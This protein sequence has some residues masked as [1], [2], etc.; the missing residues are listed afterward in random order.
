METIILWILVSI[1]LINIIKSIVVGST[2][3]LLK[4][5]LYGNDYNKWYKYKHTYIPK[6][7]RDKFKK[8]NHK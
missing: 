3:S 4:G 2:Y 5:L 8:I 6:N 1:I 7:K